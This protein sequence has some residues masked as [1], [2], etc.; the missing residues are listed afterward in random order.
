MRKTM[1]IAS[2]I[3]LVKDL[4]AEKADLLEAERND[5]VLEEVGGAEVNKVAYSFSETQLRLAGLDESVRN[6]RHAINASNASTPITAL[7]MTP[8][9]VLV[10]MAQ[11]NQRLGQLQAMAR[12]PERKRAEAYGVNQAIYRVRNFNPVEVKA[13]ADSL[14]REVRELQLELDKHNLTTEV[15]FD[16]V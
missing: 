9:C 8:D 4:E 13:V 14:R 11:K 3:K 7:G 15:T 6:I 1:C 2:A 16:L 10:T 5:S 12:M